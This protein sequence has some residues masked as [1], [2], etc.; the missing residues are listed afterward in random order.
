MKIKNNK[1]AIFFV[2]ILVGM[3]IM[4]LIGKGRAL[5]RF[6]E[7]REYMTTRD[8]MNNYG[9]GLSE[10]LSQIYSSNLSEEQILAAESKIEQCILQ[11]G[12]NCMDTMSAVNQIYEY[13]YALKYD[14][15]EHRKTAYETI[16]FE[17]GDCLGK[18]DLFCKITK[19][20]GIE[21]FIIPIYPDGPKN[22]LQI[23]PEEI[24]DDYV[25][26]GHAING[27]IIQNELYLIDCCNGEFMFQGIYGDDNNVKKRLISLEEFPHS[28]ES[29]IE[30]TEGD[31]CYHFKYTIAQQIEEQ[32]CVLFSEKINCH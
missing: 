4:F 24:W 28:Y 13:I 3:C 9:L 14:D 25:K 1:K 11:Q 8:N 15:D 22:V 26:K 18:A 21:S 29:S 30:L 5:Q 31:E 19:H 20:L 23:L 2:G 7:I 12:W 16:Y 27:V 32:I 6:F 10:E 17:T